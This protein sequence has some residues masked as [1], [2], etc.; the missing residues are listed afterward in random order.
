VLTIQ[1]LLASATTVRLVAGA[2]EIARHTRSSPERRR[3]G[4]PAMLTT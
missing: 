2:E 1:T 4:P 3:F